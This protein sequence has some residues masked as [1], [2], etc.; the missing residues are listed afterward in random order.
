MG[1]ISFCESISRFFNKHIA[2]TFSKG[3][4]LPVGN[5]KETETSD[6]SEKNKVEIKFEIS[7]LLKQKKESAVFIDISIPYQF[8]NRFRSYRHILNQPTIRGRR[9]CDWDVCEGETALSFSQEETNFIIENV[10]K[11]VE[12]AIRWIKEEDEYQISCTEKTIVF[13][14]GSQENESA[15]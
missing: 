15:N 14:W 7:R 6:E 1:F 5:L 8:I 13:E 12:D 3:N 2:L 4:V 11:E 10:I 9:I